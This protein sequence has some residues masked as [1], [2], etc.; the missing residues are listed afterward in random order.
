MDSEGTTAENSPL[1]LPDLSDAILE[2]VSDRN[3]FF[4]T[5]L[6]VVEMNMKR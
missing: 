6:A 2:L 5:V 4:L 3:L 1:L